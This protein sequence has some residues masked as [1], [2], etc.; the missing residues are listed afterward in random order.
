[1]TFKSLRAVAACAVAVWAC[2]GGARAADEPE[3]AG[4]LRAFGVEV[5]VR[6][7]VVIGASAAN[8]SPEGYRAVGECTSLRSLSVSGTA[9]PLSAETLPLLAGLVNLESLNTNQAWLADDDFRLF[10]PLRSLKRLALYHPSIRMPEFTGRG[11]AHLAALPALEELTYAGTDTG[12]EA[13]EAVGTLQGLRRFRTWHTGQTQAGMTHLAKL[14]NLVALR[15]GQRLPGWGSPEPSF[16]GSTIPVIAGMKT[17]EQLELTEARLTATDLAPLA[18]LPRLEKLVILTCD[19]PP[20]D[21]EKLR[22]ELPGVK[23]DFTP[24]SAEEREKTLV[25]KLKLAEPAPQ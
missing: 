15:I 20:A 7:G 5:T 1:M 12:D 19:I 13:L 23:I 14:E 21:V 2:G 24:L 18:G 22:G 17:L 6:D 9:A 3:I 11:L 16:D 25:R 8:L 10:A 4:R